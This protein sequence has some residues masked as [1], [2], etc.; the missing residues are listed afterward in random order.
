MK[1]TIAPANGGFV[2]D[3]LANKYDVRRACSC[4]FLVVRIGR[5]EMQGNHDG[6]LPVDGGGGR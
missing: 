6:Y 4:P 5:A 1:L 2:E 3:R